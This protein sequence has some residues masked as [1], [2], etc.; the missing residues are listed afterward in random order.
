VAG[1]S[2]VSAIAP[3][4]LNATAQGIFGATVFGFGAAGGGF[5]GAILL[6][7]LGGGQM[8][9]IFG[10]L[11]LVALILYILTERRLAQA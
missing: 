10:A 1:V 11:V 8:Y 3:A 2:Y 5:L 4:G 7:R 9:A 6:E